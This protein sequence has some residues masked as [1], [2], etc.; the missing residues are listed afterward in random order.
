MAENIINLSFN[1]VSHIEISQLFEF[2]TFPDPN[3]LF[4]S[5]I[6]INFDFL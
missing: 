6:L 5:N 1:L 4:N 2:R 3:F